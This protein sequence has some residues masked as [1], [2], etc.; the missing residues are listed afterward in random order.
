MPI[1]NVKA[2][3]VFTDNDGLPRD[4]YTNTLAFIASGSSGLTPAIEAFYNDVGTGGTNPICTYLSECIDRSV[5]V[6]IRYYDVS[7]HL[8][9]SAAGGPFEVDSFTLGAAAGGY[10]PLPEQVCVA[11]SFYDSLTTVGDTTPSHRGRIYVGPLSTFSFTHDSFEHCTPSGGFTADVAS[12]AASLLSAD[13]GWAVWSRAR[14]AMDAIE[15][16]F[17]EA[18]YDV[19]RRRRLETTYRTLWP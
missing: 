15:G 2:D 9:G 13:V 3:I 16:G 18:T 8:N 1:T 11:L 4:E 6:T 19:Q 5:D 10:V 7:A 14:A 12:A 17:I